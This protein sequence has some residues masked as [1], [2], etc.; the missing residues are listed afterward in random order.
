[1]I[2]FRVVTGFRITSTVNR[3]QTKWSRAVRSVSEL[4]T[5]H[6]EYVDER[7]QAPQE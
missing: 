7:N 1:M 4:P 6:E 2:S 5:I 3:L